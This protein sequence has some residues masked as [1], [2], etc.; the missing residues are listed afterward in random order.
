MSLLLFISCSIRE[1]FI[2]SWLMRLSWIH[3]TTLLLLC[4]YFETTN[5]VERTFILKG[6]GPWTCLIKQ[7]EDP[8]KQTKTKKES[9][10]HLLLCFIVLDWETTDMMGMMMTIKEAQWLLIPPQECHKAAD[11]SLRQPT[12][13]LDRYEPSC[14]FFAERCSSSQMM[15]FYLP[16]LEIRV[17]Q[18][19]YGEVIKLRV[20]KEDA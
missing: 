12:S 14:L 5:V 1:T 9:T 16:P 18:V 10:T 15:L 11:M 3:F 7:L 6:G 20:K 8:K 17:R 13:T 2:H 4:I 19:V